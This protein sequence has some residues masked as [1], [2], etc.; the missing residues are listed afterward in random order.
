MA[1]GALVTT[2]VRA[3]GAAAA[4]CFCAGFT[5][6][7]ATFLAGIG[8]IKTFRSFALATDVPVCDADFVNKAAVPGAG[9]RG[10][11]VDVSDDLTTSAADG[12]WASVAS[13]R[14]RALALSPTSVSLFAL[15]TALSPPPN[16]RGN[17]V[18]VKSG[19]QSALRFSNQSPL[20]VSIQ[21]PTV[22]LAS[23][24]QVPGLA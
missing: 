6:A 12:F 8:L 4:A 13:F 17:Q 3:C 15:A 21:P 7:F 18:G 1:A 11:K 24:Y 14:W 20:T 23:S 19:N 22:P 2:A 5:A 10:H 16:Q 9:L